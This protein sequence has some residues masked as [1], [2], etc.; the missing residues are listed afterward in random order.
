MDTIDYIPNPLSFN[1]NLDI[2]LKEKK[3]SVLIVSRLKEEQKKVGTSLEI[4]KKLEEYG[5]EGWSLDIVG[6]G[7]DLDFYLDMV[8]REDI[9]MCI[10]RP[11]KSC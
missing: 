4:W 6:Y 11:S 10:L 8:R 5:Y 9:K 7:D 3:K 1:L 2:D